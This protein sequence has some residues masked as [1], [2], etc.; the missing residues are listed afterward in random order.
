MKRSW[1]KWGKHGDKGRQKSDRK[2]TGGRKRKQTEA[3]EWDRNREEG[4]QGREEGA[5]GGSRSKGTQG[6]GRGREQGTREERERRERGGET[7]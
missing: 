2:R 3:G 4:T 6:G 7:A 5:D 1:R